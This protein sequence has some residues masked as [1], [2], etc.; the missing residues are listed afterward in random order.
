M[1]RYS[2]SAEDR[3]TMLC[4]F[5]FHEMRDFPSRTQYPVTEQRVS[6]HE[7]QSESQ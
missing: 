3:D 1:G 4:F 2:A 5:D 7:A 6:G